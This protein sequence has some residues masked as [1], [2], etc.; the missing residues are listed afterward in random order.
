[1]TLV[2]GIETSCDETAAAVISGQGGLAPQSSILSNVVHSQIDAHSAYGGVVPELAARAHADKIDVVIR[3]AL[4]VANC[5]LA[6]LDAIAVTAGPGLGG[7]LIVGTVTARALGLASG[8]PVIAI[9]HLEGHAL[10]ARLTDQIAYPYLLLLV[11]GG[12]T[13]IIA[14]E[15]L[16][17]YRRMA[18]TIDDALGEAFDKTAKLLGLGYPGGPAVE[19]EAMHG[20]AARFDLPRPMR[21]HARPD[22]SFSGLKTAVRQAA[23]AHAPLSHRDVADICASFQRAVTET[24]CER[25]GRA[26]EIFAAEHT[27]SGRQLVV[28]GGV[29]ANGAIRE[30]LAALAAEADY[31]LYAAPIAL[32][33]DNAA[34]IAWAGLERFEASMTDAALSIRTR[35]PLDPSSEPLLG[36]GKRGAKA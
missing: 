3:T 12:H 8:K 27:N 29:A 17:Q 26:M 10:T 11:S 21:G 24:L 36:G 13:Q 18:T 14:V 34:M 23:Q 33:G 6:D 5:A 25:V 15:A 7:G 31:S 19:R 4:D 22:F 28:A 16:G 32:A 1:M 35:W 9:N 30:A 20:D 2:L